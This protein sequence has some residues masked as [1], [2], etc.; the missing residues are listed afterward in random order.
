[1]KDFLKQLQF[2]LDK[3]EEVRSNL[4]GLEFQY[5]NN[6]AIVNDVDLVMGSLHLVIYIENDDGDSDILT[7]SFS[8]LLNEV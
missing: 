4:Q 8:D 5:K 1:M 3:I 2:H 6:Y 7:V